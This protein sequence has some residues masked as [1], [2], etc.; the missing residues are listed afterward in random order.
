MALKMAKEGELN[1]E[2]IKNSIKDL[3]SSSQFTS[4]DYINICD[5]E[6]L[7]DIERVKNKSLLAMAVKI[8]NTRLIDN[9]IINSGITDK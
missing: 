5:P 1:S 8:G 6:T 3:I 9:C 7:E 4:I 2:R